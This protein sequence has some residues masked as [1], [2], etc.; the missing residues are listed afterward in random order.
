MA[1]TYD[2][3]NPAANAVA[4]NVDVSYA[5]VATQPKAARQQSAPCR[6]AVRWSMVSTALEKSVATMAN[7]GRLRCRGGTSGATK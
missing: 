2:T 1:A 6:G 3:G 4:S 5:L 7:A